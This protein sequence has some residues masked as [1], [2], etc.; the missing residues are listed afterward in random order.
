MHE[1]QETLFTTLKLKDFVPADH[2]L[3]P[4]LLLVNEALKRLNG[5]FSVIYAGSVRASIAPGKLVRALLLQVFYSVHSVRMHTRWCPKK[6]T[7]TYRR[8]N[9]SSINQ[10]S[11]PRERV[12]LLPPRPRTIYRVSKPRYD[13]AARTSTWP[14]RRCVKR[15]GRAGR[16]RA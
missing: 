11:M 5:L 1:M 3:R 7:S 12:H 8:R 16:Q 9:E 14:A 15:A 6:R 4:I 13:R 2:P 10:R